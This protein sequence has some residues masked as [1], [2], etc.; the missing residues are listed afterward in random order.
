[1]C[2]CCSLRSLE[3]KQGKKGEVNGGQKGVSKESATPSSI[4]GDGIGT[5][6]KSRSNWC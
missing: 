5:E 2:L 1:M 3:E 6:D 4:V